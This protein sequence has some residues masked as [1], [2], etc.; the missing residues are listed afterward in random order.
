[1]SGFKRIVKFLT[2]LWQRWSVLLGIYFTLK[3]D[4]PQGQESLLIYECT[5][6]SHT[7]KHPCGSNSHC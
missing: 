3:K 6:P 7:F 1:M 4:G 5:L 2:Y